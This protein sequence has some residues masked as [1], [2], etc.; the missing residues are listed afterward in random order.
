M[1][2]QVDGCLNFDH[3]FFLKMVLVLVITVGPFMLMEIWRS[4]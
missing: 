1:T 4:V 3:V 2:G